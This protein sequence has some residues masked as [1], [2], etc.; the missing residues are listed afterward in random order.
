MAHTIDYR[1]NTTRTF[2]LIHEGAD[3]LARFSVNSSWYL[4][5]TSVGSHVLRLARLQRVDD[6]VSSERVIDEEQNQFH[7]S[8]AMA[9]ASCC[10]RRVLYSRD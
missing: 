5:A 6:A 7:L 3:R 8:T 1:E 9:G 10:V 2:S 4:Y